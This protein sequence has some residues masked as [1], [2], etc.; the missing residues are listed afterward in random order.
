MG[1]NAS[2]FNN[3]Q[4]DAWQLEYDRNLKGSMYLKPVT[5]A[6]SIDIV[7]LLFSGKT[8]IESILMDISPAVA[9]HPSWSKILPSCTMPTI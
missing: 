6:G 3:A 8:Y 2:L 9:L 5:A 7:C 1:S 4:L